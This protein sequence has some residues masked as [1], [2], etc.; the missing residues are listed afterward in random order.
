[1]PLRPPSPLR[2]LIVLA[3]AAGTAALA[4]PAG[5]L[6]IVPVVGRWVQ[7]IEAGEPVVTADPHEWDGKSGPDLEAAARLLFKNPHPAFS[8]NAAPATAYPLAI[9]VRPESFSEGVLRVRFK[10]LGGPSDQTAGLAFGIGPKADFF[11]V[12]YNTKD[13]NVAVWEFV[14]GARR[15][16]AHGTDHQ[17]LPLNVWHD[18]NVQIAGRRVTG[19]V[20]GALRVEHDLPRP[21][22]G[23]LGFWT[24]RDASSAFSALQVSA[25]R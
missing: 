5:P 1:M 22:S 20:N 3:L 18:L 9:V 10:L 12:R 8:K 16:L 21:V 6:E 2:V 25:A 19:T 17:Q 23:R 24:K 14:D 4:Q 11:Y 7:S 15:V 13:G